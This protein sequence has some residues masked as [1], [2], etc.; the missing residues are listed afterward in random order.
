MKFMSIGYYT[1]GV[2]DLKYHK[3]DLSMWHQKKRKKN[4]SK[5]G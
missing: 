3:G 4:S 1:S 5:K 2:S